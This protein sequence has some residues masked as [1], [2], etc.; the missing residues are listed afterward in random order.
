MSTLDG[1]LDAI[2][3]P[4]RTFDPSGTG[5]APAG[6]HWRQQVRRPGGHFAGIRFFLDQID[7]TQCPRAATR[8][9]L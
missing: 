4:Q 7:T 8:H 5:R 1:L 9:G 3:A 6:A 2:T